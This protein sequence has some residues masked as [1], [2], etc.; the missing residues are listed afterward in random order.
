MEDITRERTETNQEFPRAQSASA[1]CR[2][3]RREGERRLSERR[4]S[5]TRATGGTNVMSSFESPSVEPQTGFPIGQVPEQ[6]DGMGIDVRAGGSKKETRAN[7]LDVNENLSLRFLNVVRPV[8][9]H[10]DLSEGEYSPEGRKKGKEK[11]LSSQI[12]ERER[13]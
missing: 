9:N 7:E 4:V 1:Y 3:E 5:E 13:R 2:S 11:K 10:S 6:D 12:H 8:E